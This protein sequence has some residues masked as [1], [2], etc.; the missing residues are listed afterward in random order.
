LRL[1]YRQLVALT[2]VL[3]A[4]LALPVLA[5]VITWRERVPMQA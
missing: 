4:A 3:A 1:A 5:I 2:A